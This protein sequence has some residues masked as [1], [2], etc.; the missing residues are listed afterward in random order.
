MIARLKR[1]AI[2]G[3]RAKAA[4]A[5]T[6]GIDFERD[7]T[8]RDEN[9]LTCAD[10]LIALGGFGVGA[11]QPGVDDTRECGIPVSKIRHSRNPSE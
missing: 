9:I 6:G 5:S 3:C 11:N 10:R 2:C 8:K 1:H 7:R 4:V